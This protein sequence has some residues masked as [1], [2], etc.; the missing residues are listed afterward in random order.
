MQFEV[1]RSSFQTPC[2]TVRWVKSTSLKN[3]CVITVSFP[4]IK[5]SAACPT[6]PSG[7]KDREH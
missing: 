3:S 4:L 6:V 2:G 5:P 7:N 1:A